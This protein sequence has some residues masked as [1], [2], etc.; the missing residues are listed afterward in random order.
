MK[1][2]KIK[3]KFFVFLVFSF[4]LTIPSTFASTTDGTIDSTYKYAYGENVG[5]IDFGS[6]AGNVHITDSVLTGSAYGEN[7][8]WIN[9][10]GVTNS[11]GT[12]SGYA[13][14]EN[15]GFIDF[16]KV[17]IGD[18]GV[19]SGSAYG[20]NIGWITFGTTNNKV[21]TDWR[22]PSLR[23]S[24]TSSG[25]SY[26]YGCKDAKATNYNAFSVSKPELCKYGVTS[27]TS[28][29]TPTAQ[30]L[31][32]GKCSP[33][34][35]ITDNLKQGAIDGKYNIYNNG[36]VKQVN[37]LQSHINR[38][39]ASS[40]KQASGPVDGVFGQLT[41]QG[42][43]R[44]QEALNTIFAY[45]SSTPPLKIDGIVGP[46]TKEAINNSCGK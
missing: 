30:I 24:H 31:G 40:Y 34:L 16:S 44:L 7:I 20:E 35:I 13:W 23:Q 4:L 2:N 21:V 26:S 42:V 38:I 11:S 1:K 28:T 46:F 12:L 14:G 17:T 3:L 15:V 36:T 22:K 9:L 39:L 45:K 37:I 33:E 5:F 32:S 10:S 18:D 41:K 25:G 27:S 6:T 43:M 8:G 19:F 29:I